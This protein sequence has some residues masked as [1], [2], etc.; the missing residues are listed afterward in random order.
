MCIVGR[1]LVTGAGQKVK[2][3]NGLK[4]WNLAQS[5]TVCQ[6]LEAYWFWVRRS[7]VRG[8]RSSPL[9]C[10][11]SHCCRTHNEEHLPLPIFIHAASLTFESAWICIATD[12]TSHFSDRPICLYVT[13]RGYHIVT[14]DLSTSFYTYLS[15]FLSFF[16]SAVSPRISIASSWRCIA[17]ITNWL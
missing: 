8:A 4:T 3:L 10:V 5:S 12:V 13:V 1:V 14:P 15:F 11:F 6:R 16:P 9:A 2:V 17:V 7:R